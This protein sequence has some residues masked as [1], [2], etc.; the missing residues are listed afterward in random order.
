M[1]SKTSNAPEVSISTHE[2][3]NQEIGEM[4]GLEAASSDFQQLAGQTQAQMPR[5]MPTTRV[6]VRDLP[7]PP[8]YVDGEVD[9]SEQLF[10]QS[11]SHPSKYV[12]NFQNSMIP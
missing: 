1:H 6:L 5:N 4:H 12:T 9:K 8:N 3:Y 11:S 10:P 2:P 7:P